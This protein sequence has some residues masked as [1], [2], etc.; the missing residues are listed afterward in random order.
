MKIL[1]IGSGGREHAM[2]WRLSQS[3]EVEKI[4]CAPGNGGIA[5]IAEC[6]PADAADVGAL[7]A[8]A[9][10]LKP[11][12]TVV[13]PEAPL[14]A[15]IR[16]KFEC[17]GMRLV[18]PSQRDA[19]LEGSKIYAKQFMDR[20]DIPT[21]TLY[22]DFESAIEA[23]RALDAVDWPVVI[24]ADGLCAGKGVLVAESRAEAESFI[25]RV[26]QKHELGPGGTRLLFEH[27]LKGQELS[28][29][30][31]TDGKTFL[32]MAPTRDHKRV[33]D[34]DLGPNTGGMGAFTM[35]GMITPKYESLILKDIVCPTIK[36]LSEEGIP[37]TGFLYFGL[38]LT[39]SGPMVLEY[40]CRLGD[41]ETQPIMMRMDFDL[42]VA[43]DAVAS[44]KLDTIK[45]AWKT[46]ASA[47][48]VMA[49]AGYP[50]SFETGRE[51][52]GLAEAA[53]LPDVAVFHAGT[54]REGDSIVTSGGRVLGV[55]ALGESL[56]QAVQKAYAAASKIH[57]DG[58]QF[59]TDIG[60]KGDLRNS[61]AVE[62]PR[63]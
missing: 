50:G 12:F 56:P 59:R 19:R 44:R 61:P 15:G 16:N 25:R 60:A 23:I 6:V 20:Y 46:G 21:P 18:G 22:G 28:F 3:P 54:R 41:P 10:R 32:P 33:F 4:W 58:A 43:F 40:N 27:A 30:V 1:V 51:I 62:V 24:K 48:V 47:C 42:A 8:L 13:G 29:I 9:E 26:M 63:V 36:G 14:V 57:F 52:T 2:I 55:T 49:S 11:D 53:A 5:D 31:L 39:T 35:D 38:M 45:P 37:Y 17:R 7:V 34:G